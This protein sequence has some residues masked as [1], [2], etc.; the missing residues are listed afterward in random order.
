MLKI[1]GFTKIQ[2]ETLKRNFRSYSGIPRAKHEVSL[3]F[4]GQHI[5][6]LGFTGFKFLNLR[7]SLGFNGVEWAQTSFDCQADTSWA[8]FDAAQ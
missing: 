7:F 6:S 1:C 4:N 2:W 3:G 5:R 8:I